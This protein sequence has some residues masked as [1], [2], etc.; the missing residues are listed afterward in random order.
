MRILKPKDIDVNRVIFDEPKVNKNQGTNVPMRYR[1]K[2]GTEERL[3]IQTPKLKVPFGLSLP[4]ADNKDGG[5]TKNEDN[6]N[7]YS[8]EPSFGNY[9]GNKKLEE[10]HNAMEKLDNCI[11]T[12]GGKNAMLWN[13]DNDDEELHG[14]ALDKCYRSIFKYSRDKQTKKFNTD[15]PPRF[16]AKLKT[17]GKYSTL[18]YDKKQQQVNMFD[19]LKP[20]KDNTIVGIISPCYVYVTDG[21]FGVV[22][23][24]IQVM[25]FGGDISEKPEFMQDSDIDTDDSSDDEKTKTNTN[26]NT[27]N[28]KNEDEEDDDNDND[29]DS[30][31]NDSDNE[32]TKISDAITKL[33]KNETETEKE[34]EPEPEPEPEH[35]PEPEQEDTKKMRK[36]RSRKTKQ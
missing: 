2:D 16:R 29:S 21:K 26:T 3:Y 35:E 12:A 19:V 11:K 14:K 1:H 10:F 17:I 9:K 28:K 33:N 23:D 7:R 36:P 32:E 25:V 15:Y 27:N 24:T 6:S 8:I 18:F 5:E 4:M 13:I 20:K 30:D 34:S 22:I 31:E